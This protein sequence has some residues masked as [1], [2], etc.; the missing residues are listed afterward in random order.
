M[1]GLREAYITAERTYIRAL[2]KE[3]QERVNLFESYVDTYFT[4]TGEDWE[5]DIIFERDNSVCDY[6]QYVKYLISKNGELTTLAGFF[7]GDYDSS[8]FSMSD[9]SYDVPTLE[10]LFR[11]ISSE[12][13]SL[14]S[15]F[16]EMFEVNED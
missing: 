1:K 16:E 14:E 15:V 5:M 7:D 6:N 13:A 8:P 2:Q 3:I 9:V 10:S 12:M 11:E 4:L